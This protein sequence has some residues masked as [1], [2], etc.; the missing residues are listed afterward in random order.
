M[1]LVSFENIIIWRSYGRK[2]HAYVFWPL[3]SYF[4]ANWTEIFHVEWLSGGIN[5]EFLGKI[6][7]KFIG[8]QAI[9]AGNF[10][11]FFCY[12]MQVFIHI[13]QASLNNIVV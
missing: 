13:F 7:K 5:W 9:F 2:W 1:V 4:L 11:I 10:P 12:L 3:L 8:D 6:G